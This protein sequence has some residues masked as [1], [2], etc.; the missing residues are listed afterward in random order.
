MATPAD[1]TALKIID[2]TYDVY[3]ASGEPNQYPLS[4]IN[5]MILV[6]T[7]AGWEWYDEDDF[8]TYYK[9]VNEPPES[10]TEFSPV[11]LLPDP[12]E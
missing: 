12:P 5:N 9:W 4:L 10:K 11:E 7:S 1:M 3:Q 8:H 6:K 2:E